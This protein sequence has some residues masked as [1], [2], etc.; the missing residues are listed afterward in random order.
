MELVVDDTNILIDLANTDLLEYCK[1]MDIQFHTTDIAIYEV[2]HSAQY[3]KVQK[4]IDEGVL[5]VN[6]LQD[7]DFIRFQLLYR[8]LQNT[9]NLTPEDCSVMFLAES[10]HCRLLTSD[11]KL[12]RQAELRGLSVNG[13]LWLTDQMMEQK[14]LS[15]ERMIETLRVLL[16]TNG[17]APRDLIEERISLYLEYK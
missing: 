10:L 8:E 14:L 5:I 7:K 1:D 15:P 3:A 13:L 17:R 9:T 12:K 2:R 16:D 6:E 4:M 11:Q